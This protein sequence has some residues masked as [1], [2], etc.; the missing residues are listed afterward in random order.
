M[1]ASLKP[2]Q[3]HKGGRDWLASIAA[4]SFVLSSLIKVIHPKLFEMGMQG[5]LAMQGQADLTEVLN[6]W[7]SIFNGVRVIGNRQAG[8]TSPNRN[9]MTY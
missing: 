5:M 1:S 9:G 4:S 3:T 2:E 8:T 6:L 7:Y